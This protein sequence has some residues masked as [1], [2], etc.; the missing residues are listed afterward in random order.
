MTESRVQI[1]RGNE[2]KG[3][4]KLYKGNERKLDN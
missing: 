4:Q 3:K 1:M 2:N